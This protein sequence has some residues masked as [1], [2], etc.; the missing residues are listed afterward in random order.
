MEYQAKF[1]VG[2]E[3]KDVVTGVEGIVMCVAFW[4]FGCTRYAIQMSMDPKTREVPEIQW[5]DEPQIK[6]IYDPV[7]FRPTM[8]EQVRKTHGPRSDPS[9]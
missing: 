5:V 8:V 6:L 2:S 4:L 7:V 9:K 1:E 3:V